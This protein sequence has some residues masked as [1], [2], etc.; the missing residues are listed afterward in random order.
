MSCLLRQCRSAE[1]RRLTQSWKN[2]DDQFSLQ[3]LV[4]Q[5]TSS[6][7]DCIRLD[8]MGGSAGLQD[9][10]SEHKAQRSHKCRSTRPA[11]LREP[12]CLTMAPRCRGGTTACTSVLLFF[13]ACFRPRFPGAVHRAAGTTTPVLSASTA[14]II[15]EGTFPVLVVP[16]LTPSAPRSEPLLGSVAN[17]LLAS[18]P[19][20]D[21]YL[22]S[23]P[24]I[25]GIAA[26]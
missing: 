1:G 22:T 26:R 21:L 10:E 16:S 24:T 9:P 25:L 14:P 2:H 20:F 11:E 13:S 19:I 23:V 4:T 15:A 17:L 12:L 5:A 7:Y 6:D 18:Y 3:T 8:A